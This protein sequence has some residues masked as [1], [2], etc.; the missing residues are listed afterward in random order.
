MKFSQ[1]Q[2]K[3]RPATAFTLM[4]VLVAVTVFMI[5]LAALNGVY[6]GAL[7]LQ[8]RTT[9][10][11]QDIR[12]SETAITVLKKDIANV[13][14]PSGTFVLQL[15]S[16]Y[17]SGITTQSIVGV[18]S[19]ILLELYT[20]NGKIEDSVPWGDVQK[21]D[22]SLETPLNRGTAMG[23]DL[24]RTVTR[25]FL[26]T[27]VDTPEQQRILHDVSK[28]TVNFYDGTNW[29]DVWGG[30]SSET[31][32]TVPAAIRVRVEMATERNS[33]EVKPPIE[34]LVPIMVCPTYTTNS[35]TTNSTTTSSSSSK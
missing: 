27:M 35:T 31:N 2:F 24:T 8:M 6:Y 32:T 5:V 14:L 20:S 4:E 28:F 12:P 26:S 9:A 25:N 7:H 1:T 18:N 22:Y 17:S 16:G 30:T 13:M 3:T 19:P 15:N 29:S 23:L 11:I 34:L 21:I 33:R 10:A